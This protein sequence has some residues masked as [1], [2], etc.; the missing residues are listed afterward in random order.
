MRAAFVGHPLADQ[1][2]LEVDRAAARAALGIA[3]GARVLAV[4]PGSRRG[5]VEKLARSFAG[6][7]E[8]L[9]RTLSGSRHVRADGDARP[10]DLFAAR[11]EAARAH[12]RDPPARRAGATRAR[13]RGR[14]ARRLRHRHARNRAVARPMVV[15]YK[16]RRHHGFP[17]AYA[18]AR[19]DQAFLPAE[20]ARGQGARARVLPGAC[21]RRRIS[22]TRWP[23]GSSILRTWRGCSRNSPRIHARLR[24]DG[25]ERAA[26]EI[27]DLV[28]A[29]WRCHEVARAPARRR[30]R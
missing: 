14:R 28:D 9:A 7:A 15:A 17:A 29:G 2:P 19:E 4:L 20:P 1:I 10:R 25:A 21:E 3:A 26:A 12:G 30:S 18:R 13:C 24:C 23:A 11:C 16:P 5:E 8:L 22:R 6:A 27:A